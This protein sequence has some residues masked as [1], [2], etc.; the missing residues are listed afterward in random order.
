[1]MLLYHSRPSPSKMTKTG[2]WTQ[3]WGYYNNHPKMWVL[4]WN[5]VQRSRVKMTPF[6]Q[7]WSIRIALVRTLKEGNDSGRDVTLF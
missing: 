1:M 4:L 6:Y 5:L 3:E 2:N 7:E